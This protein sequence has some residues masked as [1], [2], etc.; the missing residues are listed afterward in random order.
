[1]KRKILN[2]LQNN[3]FDIYGAG[4]SMV[5]LIS[6]F[7]NLKNINS[8]YDSQ[9]IKHSKIFPG[10]NIRILKNKKSNLKKIFFSLS[11]L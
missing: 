3:K 1:M 11:K 2:H 8:V 10:T 9:N 6:L 4:G 5:A 7:N